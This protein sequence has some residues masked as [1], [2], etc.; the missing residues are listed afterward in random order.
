MVK[1]MERTYLAFVKEEDEKL[2]ADLAAA[3][4]QAAAQAAEKQRVQEKQW[5]E[6]VRLGSSQHTPFQTALRRP[7]KT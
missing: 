2:E 6:I 1:L 7:R 4:Q 5:A 3:D